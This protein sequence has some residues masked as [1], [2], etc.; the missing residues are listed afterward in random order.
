MY[1]SSAEV[2]TL[3]YRSGDPAIINL[4]ETGQDVYIHTAKNML[5]EEKWE[6]LNKEEK[7]GYRKIFKIVTLAVA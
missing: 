5:G 4:F 1:C 2:R 3:A 7:A 6:T